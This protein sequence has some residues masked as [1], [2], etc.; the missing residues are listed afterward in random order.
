MYELEDVITDMCTN[1]MQFTRQSNKSSTKR[2][3]NYEMRCYDGSECIASM[4]SSG[5]LMINY[6]NSSVTLGGK[7][8][9]PRRKRQFMT[10][11]A[12]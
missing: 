6:R 7:N 9:V 3:E 10:W 8:G 11:E 12:M 1:M 2:V 5:F 4:Y